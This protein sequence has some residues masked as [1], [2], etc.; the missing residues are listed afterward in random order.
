MPVDLH[1]TSQDEK[2]VGDKVG[3]T[4][5]GEARRGTIDFIGAQ[6]N[7]LIIGSDGEWIVLVKNAEN[8]W[9]WGDMLV[10]LEA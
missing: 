6:G 7:C 4:L 3:F 5:R 1:L 8:Q 9:T 10:K 2:Q